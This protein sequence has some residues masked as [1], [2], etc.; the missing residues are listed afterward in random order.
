MVNW[1]EWNAI[2]ILKG[3]V[4]GVANI[5]PGVSGGTLAVVLGIYDNLV[6]AIGDLF[7]TSKRRKEN[8]I[9]LSQIAFGAVLAIF[10]ISSLMDYVYTNHICPTVYFFIGLIIGSIPSILRQHTDMRPTFAN[11]FFFGVGVLAILSLSA[12]TTAEST[13]ITGNGD[14]ILLFFAGVAAAAAMIVPGFSGSFVLL[15]MGVYWELIDAVQAFDLTVLVLPAI[16]GI[17]GI[18]GVSKIIGAAI[19]KYPSK[20]YYLILGLIVASI[21]ELYPGIPEN[22][23]LIISIISLACGIIIS[24]M[25]SK[26]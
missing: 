23:Q 13:E 2:I 20:V 15:A 14:L 19:R 9:F 22:G 18:V 24:L 25:L 17:I 10:I 4:I 21:W 11:I 12:I 16:G 6:G 1:K 3:A 5:I 8:F 7:T 26:R